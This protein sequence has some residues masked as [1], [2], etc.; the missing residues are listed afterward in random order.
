MYVK[1]ENKIVI[2][3]WPRKHENRIISRTFASS[4]ALPS[5]FFD[6][7]FLAAAS[8]FFFSSAS[9]F[10]ASASFFLASASAFLLAWACDWNSNNGITCEN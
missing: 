8:A 3:Q 9:A 1:N 4:A 7:A 6:S 5:S 10:L 2:A